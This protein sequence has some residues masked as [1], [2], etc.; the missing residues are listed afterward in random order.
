MNTAKTFTEIQLYAVWSNTDLTEGRG[1]EYVNFYCL[2][3]STAK[4]KARRNYIMGSTSPIT[5]VDAFLSE[6]GQYIVPISVEVVQPTAEDIEQE[7]LVELER[8]KEQRK[9]EL[10]KSLNLTKEQL[11]LLGLTK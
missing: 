2:N 7:R 10:I 3:E 8:T 5:V 6:D 1:R 9:Q 4:R 11:D